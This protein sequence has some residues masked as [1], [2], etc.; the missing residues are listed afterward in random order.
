MSV[1][2][3]IVKGYK[4]FRD[5]T[6][7]DLKKLTILS[8]ANSSGKSSIMQPILLLKQ[9]YEA[10]YDPGPLLINGPNVIFSETNQMLWSEP[11]L[12]RES[13]FTWGIEAGRLDQQICVE[14]TLEQRRDGPTP[15]GIR[16][17]IWSWDDKQVSLSE[18]MNPDEI[19]SIADIADEEEQSLRSILDRII[20]P[21]NGQASVQY[22]VERDRA[23][24]KI[25]A[26][27]SR[28]VLPYVPDP[29]RQ[30]TFD[31][32]LRKIIHV[33]ALR[34]NPRRT[35]PVTAVEREF[36]GVFQDYVASVIAHWQ[37]T[38]RARVN[39]LGRD[40]RHLGL[41][42]KVRSQQKSDTEVEIL[43]GRLAASRRGGSRDLV[44]IADVGFGFSQLL[45]VLVA[46]LA[47]SP[48]QLVYIE[49][50]EIHLHPRAQAALP[51]LVQRAVSRGVQVVVETHSE[52]FL[53]G[54]Q[55]LVA[56]GDIAPD[57][58]ALQ[59]FTRDEF[60]VTRIDTARLDERGAFGDVPVDF[61]ET[62]MA[63]V[64]EY[65]EASAGR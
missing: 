27:E 63:A 35:Y 37:K 47:A 8:G 40:L 32:T 16:E 6:K 24:L 12:A 3:L 17:C 28:F 9:T 62:S 36:P 2:N 49:Q 38:D 15:L 48:D 64:R 39:Q 5:R 26:T 19:W 14:V 51:N 31:Q 29:M 44:S 23:V 42:W 30:A 34:G 61:A 53:L 58:V 18:D 10:S 52:L 57:D 65:L 22:A 50:P 33:P 46:L 20:P 13:C 43:V 41:S 11:G 45:P 60:G 54:I 59:W 55:K 7:M 21:E 25:V 4:S 1:N 56:K